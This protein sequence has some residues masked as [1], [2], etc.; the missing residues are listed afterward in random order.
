[1]P[2][3]VIVGGQLGSEG[4]GKVAKCIA[5]QEGASVAIRCGGPNSGH[6]VINNN[7]EAIVFQQLPTACLLSNI[8]SVLSAG[9]YIDLDILFSEIAKV[10]IDKEKLFID[11]K[12]VIIT[13]RMKKTEQNGTLKE[14]IGSTGSGTGEAVIHRIKRTDT[15]TFAKDIPALSPYIKDVNSFLRSQLKK[16]KRIILEGTQGFG[17]SLI[18]SP[19]YPNV[20]SRDTT[21]SGFLAEAGLSPLDVDD[22]VMVIR[23]FPIRVPGNSGHLPN[24]INWDI[25]RQESGAPFDLAEITS[26][27]KKVRRVAKFDS[28]IVR[29]AIQINNPTRVVLN[30]VDYVDFSIR[31]KG[32]TLKASKF[33]DNISFEINKKIEM[34]GIDQKDIFHL[35]K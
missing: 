30:H 1:M 33:I 3:S 6:T 11:P 23:A 12:A 18:H 28:E 24:E 8:I 34:Y 29:R 16:K 31:K 5:E 20:T 15:L 10:R 27:T 32:M 2:I 9:M 7:G 14:R 4:K 22:V 35:S 13:E 17:L 19:Y 26:V 25:L 21:A